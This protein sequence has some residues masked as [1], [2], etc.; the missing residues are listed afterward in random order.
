[1]SLGFVP[2]R[3]LLEPK[4]ELDPNDEEVA[5]V[6]DVFRNKGAACFESS[7]FSLL[8]LLLLLLKRDPVV[9]GLENNDE[10]VVALLK[11][12]FKPELPNNEVPLFPE[13][14]EFSSF[15]VFVNPNKFFEFVFNEFSLLA[16][17][18]VSCAILY[19][20]KLV[21]IQLM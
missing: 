5:E 6:S 15:F 19:I 2:K 18:P 14:S 8:L 21:S 16:L 12:L 9:A 20:L 4:I 10:V 7:F 13:L 3:D 17:L 1:M 11:E